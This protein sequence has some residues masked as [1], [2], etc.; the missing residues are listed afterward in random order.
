VSHPGPRYLLLAGGLRVFGRQCGN[1]CQCWPR[2]SIP[3][4]LVAATLF[5][6]SYWHQPCQ[7]N[8]YSVQYG[9]TSDSVECGFLITLCAD[10]NFL[11]GTT[12]DGH[13]LVEIGFATTRNRRARGLFRRMI[14]RMLFCR[15][16][17]ERSAY[18]SE[19]ARCAEWSGAPTAVPKCIEAG[20]RLRLGAKPRIVAS[21]RDQSRLV[22][23][24]D[25]ES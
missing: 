21:R 18:R 19:G 1:L 11:C 14:C 5:A 7:S 2:E 15:G 6:P 3:D 9:R 10:M 17:L 24:P 4:A 23:A 16:T 12:A 13:L 20:V 22:A 25:F 8:V